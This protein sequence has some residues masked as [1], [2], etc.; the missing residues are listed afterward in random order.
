M[1]W[2][3]L[4]PGVGNYLVLTLIGAL[5]VVPTLGLFVSSF[6]TADAV[7]RTGWWTVFSDPPSEKLSIDNYLIV[8]GNADSPLMHEAAASDEKDIDILQPFLNSLTV[9]VPATFFPICIAAAAAYGFAWLR[10]PGRRALFFVL[11]AIQVVPLQSALIPVLRDFVHLRINGTYLSV[12]IAHTG[13][14]LPLATY[15]LFNYI[16][17]IPREYVEAAKMDGASHFRIFQDII[18]PLSKPALASFAILQFLWVWNDLLVALVFLGMSKS[19]TVMTQAL[20]TLS[21]TYGNRW[22]LLTAGA[23]ISMIIPLAIFF[24]LQR[25]FVRGLTSGG[26]VE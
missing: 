14:G 7:S 17:G 8:T 24:A 10:F 22:H 11:L 3:R 6:R 25:Y 20:V 12:W 4:L 13:F 15:V 19:V 23:F 21:G 5:W 26:I 2:K 9:A 18:L 1:R 16:S